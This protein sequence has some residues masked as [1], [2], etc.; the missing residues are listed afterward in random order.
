MTEEGMA[1]WTTGDQLTHWNAALH[2]VQSAESALG[3]RGSTSGPLGGLQIS[4]HLWVTHGA[5]QPAETLKM[6]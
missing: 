5:L 6:I 1:G 4:T 3:L 2:H